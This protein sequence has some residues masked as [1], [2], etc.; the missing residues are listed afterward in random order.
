MALTSLRRFGS[1]GASRVFM[2]GM[3]IHVLRIF[4]EEETADA[5]F[6][7]II[8]DAKDE[9]AIFGENIAR[10]A[11]FVTGHL[12]DHTLALRFFE[13][14]RLSPL[15]L[16]HQTAA[17]AMPRILN[18]AFSNYTEALKLYRASFIELYPPGTLEH[19]RF[20]KLHK[21]P[22]YDELHS[23]MMS[24][25]LEDFPMR[26]MLEAF[27]YEDIG[28][29]FDTA[30]HIYKEVIELRNDP[31]FDHSVMHFEYGMFLQERR[32][33]YVG[34]RDQFMCALRIDASYCEAHYRLGLLF[35]TRFSDPKTARGHFE[36]VLRI[37]PNHEESKQIL[38][39]LR[40][41][42]YCHYYLS[43]C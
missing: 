12:R 20:Y 33:N 17:V 9:P 34:A 7:S 30:E 19:L 41:S 10:L 8:S 35:F 29:D 14:L 31:F 39:L 28:G 6:Q 5:M 27:W 21:V 26:P 32:R 16:D 11:S 43:N 3:Y 2:R 1:R 23:I 40:I 38:G 37:N 25:P 22:E 15:R 18:H 24:R 36:T 4:H 42:R 13:S